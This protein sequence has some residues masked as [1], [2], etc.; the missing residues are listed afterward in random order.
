MADCRTA[1]LVA[2]SAFFMLATSAL[3]LTLYEK[4]AEIIHHESIYTLYILFFSSLN[5][6]IISTVTH[7]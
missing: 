6:S 5:V 7:A 2:A 3:M 4:N 1:G